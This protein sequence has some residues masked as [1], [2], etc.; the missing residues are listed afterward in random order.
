MKKDLNWK[1][2]ISTFRLLGRE[3]ITDRITAIVELVKNCYDANARNVYIEFINVDDKNEG[4]IKISDDGCGM[5]ESDFIN[6][7]MV[8]G[9]D[10]KRVSHYTEPPFNRRVVGEKGIGRFAIEKLGSNCHILSRKISDKNIINILTIDWSKYENNLETDNFNEVNNQLI[11]KKINWLKN[12]TRIVIRNLHDIWSLYDIDRLYKE[13]SKIVSPFNELNPPFNI[14]IR[15]NQYQKYLL[16]TKVINNSIKYASYH[17][18]IDFDEVHQEEVKF[19][20]GKLEIIKDNIKSFGPLKFSLFYFNKNAKAQ[21]SKNNKGSEIQIDGVKIYRDGILATPF[22]EHNG[23][24]DAQRD[25]L[26]VDKRRWSGFFDRIGSRDIIGI[27][28]I[29]RNLSPKIID[30]TNRQDFI[31]NEEYRELKKF[32]IDQIHELEKYLKSKKEKLY[33]KN[34]R[35]LRGAKREIGDF[36]NLILSIKKDVNDQNYIDVENKLKTLNTQAQKVDVALKK[37]IVQQEEERRASQ[38]KEQMYMSLMSIQMF[39]LEITHI[40]KTALANI[41]R[42]AEF[43]SKYFNNKLYEN[44]CIKYGKDI[45]HEINKLNEAITFMSQYTKSNND[46]KYIDIKSCIMSLFNSYQM[47]LE[48][49][50]IQVQLDIQDNLSLEYNEYLL[51]DI[52]NNLISNSIKALTLTNKKIIKVSISCD[53][54]YLYIIFSDSGIGIKEGDQEKIFEVFYTTTVE[55]GGNGM[56]LYMVK[57]Y[58]TSLNGNIELIDSE[59][60]NGA[61]FYIKIPFKKQKVL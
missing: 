3:L 52:F 32:I 27:V 18:S 35:E 21:F 19:I 15:S 14:Y 7:W 55:D 11:I 51:K 26:G 50:K 44:L 29:Q 28:E 56:G 30:A 48:E 8:I 4:F 34:D 6:K 47:I 53:S 23:A 42:R 41:K 54:D 10:S 40:I 9:T 20:N 37:G 58:L 57:T 46:W 25:I 22:A 5:S 49:K 16:K 1:F 31:D 38:R 17:F 45:V 61:T 39:A 43:N 59:L 33:E 13:L 12:G 2:D 36:K 60:D 24:R